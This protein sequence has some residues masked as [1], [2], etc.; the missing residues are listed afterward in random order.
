MKKG[1]NNRFSYAGF[2]AQTENKGLFSYLFSTDGLFNQIYVVAYVTAALV[3]LSG[4]GWNF[5]IIAPIIWITLEII[6]YLL[7]IYRVRR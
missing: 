4:V 5:L 1:K 7:K 6:M 3:I 2:V